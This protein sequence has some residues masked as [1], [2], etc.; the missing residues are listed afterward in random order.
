MKLAYVSCEGDMER[1]VAELRC[2][3]VDD[4]ARHCHT[5]QSLIYSRQL[6]QYKAFTR[7][8]AELRRRV[9]SHRHSQQVALLDDEKQAQSQGNEGTSETVASGSVR[10]T[11]VMVTHDVIDDDDTTQRRQTAKMRPLRTVDESLNEHTQSHDKVDTDVKNVDKPS[12]SSDENFEELGTYVDDVTA[13]GGD[14]VI[15]GQTAGGGETGQKESFEVSCKKNAGEELTLDP[16]VE[17]AASDVEQSRDDEIVNEAAGTSQQQLDAEKSAAV[18]SVCDDDGSE[19]VRDDDTAAD[20]VRD[21]DVDVVTINKQRSV[22]ELSCEMTSTATDRHTAAELQASA[23][24]ETESAERSGISP[25]SSSRCVGSAQPESSRLD[26]NKSKADEKTETAGRTDDCSPVPQ[27]ENNERGNDIVKSTRSV[28]RH[29]SADENGT[30]ARQLRR[31]ASISRSG[32]KFVVL[33]K[34]RSAANTA[35]D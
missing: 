1:V 25:T 6:T 32:N 26:D 21:D 11:R 29:S 14:D 4:L 16:G 33:V 2:C 19:A 24:S 12:K 3:T 17:T 30:S 27:R 23:G 10:P 22:S 8:A 5:V 13:G 15:T 9:A 28:T 18:S 34:R 7:S 35:E 31:P 20:D